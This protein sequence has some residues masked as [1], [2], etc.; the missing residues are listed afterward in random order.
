MHMESEKPR[1]ERKSMKYT[2]IFKRLKISKDFKSFFK[3]K[4]LV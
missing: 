2:T 3:E 1:Y 4:I